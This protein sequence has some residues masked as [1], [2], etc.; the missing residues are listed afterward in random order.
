MLRHGQKLTGWC[1][2]HGAAHHE[3]MKGK[4]KEDSPNRECSFFQ[5]SFKIH[6]FVSTIYARRCATYPKHAKFEAV[7]AI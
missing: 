5:L 7:K 3:N 2:Y 4:T 1:S 6:D